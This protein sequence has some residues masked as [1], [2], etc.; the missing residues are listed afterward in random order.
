MQK[1]VCPEKNATDRIIPDQLR[2][3]VAKVPAST[4]KSRGEV[5]HIN[6]KNTLIE[7]SP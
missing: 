2:K 6:L 4:R 7:I 5:I 1:R 3:T